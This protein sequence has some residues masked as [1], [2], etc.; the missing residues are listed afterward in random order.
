MEQM[1]T[2]LLAEIR[3]SQEHMKEDLLARMEAKM[4]SRQEEMKA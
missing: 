2:C 1:L 4:G 3:T